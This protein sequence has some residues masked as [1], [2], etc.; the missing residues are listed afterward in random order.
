MRLLN[1][2]TVTLPL[3]T[4]IRSALDSKYEAHEIYHEKVL[5][6][7]GMVSSLMYNTLLTDDSFYDPSVPLDLPS[8]NYLGFIEDTIVADSFPLLFPNSNPFD[9]NSLVGAASVYLNLAALYMDSTDNALTDTATILFFTAFWKYY[10]TSDAKIG[11]TSNSG[12]Y[13]S[14]NEGGDPYFDGEGAS[15]TSGSVSYHPNLQIFINSITPS[16]G[17]LSSTVITISYTIKN[18]GSVNGYFK[19]IRFFMS[20]SPNLPTNSAGEITASTLHEI[21]DSSGM[22]LNAHSERTA[23]ISASNSTSRYFFENFTNI[24]VHGFIDYTN[25]SDEA[26][27]E[28]DNVS[29]GYHIQST[30]VGVGG[31]LVLNTGIQITH[32][33][34]ASYDD[35]FANIPRTLE[36]Q[37]S[38]NFGNIDKVAL[39][40]FRASFENNA[41]VPSPDLIRFIENSYSLQSLENNDTSVVLQVLGDGNFVNSLVTDD[42]LKEYDTSATPPTGFYFIYV[43][44]YDSTSVPLGVAR[45]LTNTTLTTST[46]VPSLILLPVTILEPPANAIMNGIGYVD[47]SWNAATLDEDSEGTL[48]DVSYN[49]FISTDPDILSGSPTV[50]TNKPYVRSFPVTA[51]NTYYWKVVPT[52][53]GCI[54]PTNN[55]THSFSVIT[56]NNTNTDEAGNSIV[57]HYSRTEIKQRIDQLCNEF[58]N[59]D[60]YIPTNSQQYFKS[61]FMLGALLRKYSIITSWDIH[62][63]NYLELPYDDFYTETYY[64]TPISFYPGTPIDD[65]THGYFATS[66]SDIF[67]T[68]LLYRFARNEI[69]LLEFDLAID[70]YNA[71]LR[72][73]LP[74]SGLTAPLFNITERAI[75]RPLIIDESTD[76][77]G[78]FYEFVRNWPML[79]YTVAIRAMISNFSSLRRRIRSIR[80]TSEDWE[81]IVKSEDK[82]FILGIIRYLL[83][84]STALKDGLTDLYGKVELIDP[85]TGLPYPTEDTTDTTTPLEDLGTS[86]LDDLNEYAA[87]TRSTLEASVGSLLSQARL[88]ATE[89]N[90]SLTDYSAKQDYENLKGILKSLKTADSALPREFFETE[91]LTFSR[92][93]L[94]NKYRNHLDAISH[95]ELM[96]LHDVIPNVVNNIDTPWFRDYY[97]AAISVKISSLLRSYRGFLYAVKS[98][99]S[100]DND[101][102]NVLSLTD[103]VLLDLRNT[104]V[105]LESFECEEFFKETL[106]SYFMQYY[107]ETVHRNHIRLSTL[108]GKPKF[109]QSLNIS[110]TLTLPESTLV[111]PYLWFDQFLVLNSLPREF[112]ETLPYYKELVLSS[113]YTYD[114]L[115]NLKVLKIP[116]DAE[117]SLSSYL[118]NITSSKRLIS[119]KHFVSNDPTWKAN[120]S[121]IKKL[122]FTLLPTK[123]LTLTSELENLAFDNSLSL[124]STLIK[125]LDY[126]YVLDPVSLPFL[127]SEGAPEDDLGVTPSQVM[128]SISYLIKRLSGLCTDIEMNT[129]FDVSNSA[130]LIHGC[131]LNDRY[132]DYQ[133]LPPIWT[134]MS[135]SNLE[136]AYDAESGFVLSGDIEE[137]AILTIDSDPSKLGKYIFTDRR[138]FEEAIAAENTYSEYLRMCIRYAIKYNVV[139][140]SS[141]YVGENKSEFMWNEAVPESSLIPDLMWNWLAEDSE[142]DAVE[143]EYELRNLLR[144]KIFVLNTVLQNYFNDANSELENNLDMMFN[145]VNIISEFQNSVKKVLTYFKSYQAEI[146]ANECSIILDDVVGGSLK[147]RDKLVFTEVSVELRDRLCKGPITVNNKKYTKLTDELKFTEISEGIPLYPAINLRDEDDTMDITELSTPFAALPGG[148]S[149]IQ[150]YLVKGV[151]LTE[152]ITVTLPTN[153]SASITE[154]PYDWQ[155]SSLVLTPA[156]GIVEQ[157]IYLRF[158]GAG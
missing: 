7:A 127:I 16:A 150:R 17:L 27:N 113:N 32:P 67:F 147:L 151:D 35:L 156:D 19:S 134:G 158:Y 77:S 34:L 10:S 25:F 84:K 149:E 109:S 143:S 48:G 57:I 114:M 141:Y 110:P 23:E 132:T 88:T 9:Y 106:K 13:S 124:A 40:I 42:I 107:L 95:N 129:M 98:E 111:E 66:P 30:S 63:L 62:I 146:T 155:E 44:A 4:A 54:T 33:T 103:N 41:W 72:T 121:D 105:V 15:G 71:E 120:E 22:V 125:Q 138:R 118:Q 28:D 85:M 86:I 91:I 128:L 154:N 142:Y 152:D 135:Q 122:N 99:F 18:V 73:M 61:I 97:K 78:C 37:W 14:Y 100:S 52:A 70:A 112:F 137:N 148:Y 130:E 104:D 119:F 136:S 108:L 50:S 2:R 145:S 94:L 64:G 29:A 47:L 133:S 82:Y 56:M 93:W 157:K 74:Q 123:Y 21:Y 102:D 43:T 3:T 139:K 89:I 12:G 11:G 87:N 1:E 83:E 68:R 51:G 69:T 75:I 126:I 38:F 59:V 39:T 90:Q 60:Y 80:D 45:I 26:G 36:V 6:V 96:G 115:T 153:F 58:L 131:M 49:V 92:T 65:E 31:S 76:Y 20:G 79:S 46:I 5:I 140:F 117:K 101:L 81:Y 24:Y 53:I 144:S 8:L 55:E 116:Y